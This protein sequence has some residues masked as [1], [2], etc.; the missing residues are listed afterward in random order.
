GLPTCFA[1][2]S[3]GSVESSG[4]TR[5]QGLF[6]PFLVAEGVAVR[7]CD[8]QAPAHAVVIL[9]GPNSGGKTRLMQS[10]ALSQLLGQGGMPVPAS[11][12]ELPRTQGLF[13]SML[14]D[15]RADQPEGRLGMELMR[16]RTL[17]EQLRP[18][19]I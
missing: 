3:Q 6:N 13:V 11:S 7:R 16:I 5:L 4:Q 12:A 2:F 10:V 18:G 8:I 17:F 15:V 9:T 14:Q 19:D 1:T